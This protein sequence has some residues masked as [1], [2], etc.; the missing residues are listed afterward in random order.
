M[1]AALHRQIE[2]SVLYNMTYTHASSDS[3]LKLDLDSTFQKGKCIA[4]LKQDIL[5]YPSTSIMLQTKNGYTLF[6]KSVIHQK[7]QITCFGDVIISRLSIHEKGKAVAIFS[8]GKFSRKKTSM[9]L[10]KD[11]RDCVQISSLSVKLI[12]L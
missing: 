4:V 12:L 7:K 2:S 3:V 8:F 1:Q 10:N 9:T 6:S 5:G 11:V